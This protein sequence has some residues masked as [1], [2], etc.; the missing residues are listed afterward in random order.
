MRTGLCHSL[1]MAGFVLGAAV[2]VVLADSSTM[3]VS[4]FL[5]FFSLDNRIS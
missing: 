1:L 3:A 4:I 2:M 5:L